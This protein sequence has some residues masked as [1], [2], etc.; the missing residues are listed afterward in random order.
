MGE[1]IRIDTN[2]ADVQHLKRVDDRLGW[3]I[4]RIGTIECNVHEE[5]FCFVVEE[6]IGQMLS[7]KMADMLIQRFEDLCEGDVSCDRVSKLHISDVRSIGISS[8]K[9]KY[10]IDF[11]Q[12]VK[13]GQFVFDDLTRMEDEQAMKYLMRV[14]GIGAWTAKMFL[15]F[16]LRRPDILPV[17]DAAFLQGFRWLYQTD[18]VTPASVKQQCKKWSPCSSVAARYLYRAVD[19][20][21]TKTPLESI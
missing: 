12:L 19:Y 14:K 20:G 9:A 16:V 2:N 4:D 8:A 7:N 5:P 6:I 3:L 1:K 13:Q 17:E 10:I 15:L 11:A 18:D 21:Y